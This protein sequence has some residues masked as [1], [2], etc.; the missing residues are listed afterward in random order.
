MR[1]PVGLL[2]IAGMIVFMYLFGLLVGYE[3][4]QLMPVTTER[5]ESKGS[6]IHQDAGQ[7]NKTKEELD[8]I[9]RLR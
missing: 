1:L 3:Y 9:G 5:T 7:T 2:L 6:L 8:I 4:H